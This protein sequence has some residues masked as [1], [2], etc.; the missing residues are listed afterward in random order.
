VD[1]AFSTV[2]VANAL[3]EI[4]AANGQQLDPMKLQKLVYIAHGWHLALADEPLIDSAVEAW[5]YGPVVPTLYQKTRRY[6]ASPIDQKLE[7]GWF[8]EL[9]DSEDLTKRDKAAWGLLERVWEE[10]GRYSGVHLSAMTHKKG[11]PWYK[12]WHDL[13][14][15]KTWGKN[16]DPEQIRDHY[17]DLARSSIEQS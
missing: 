7:R 14:G 11:T 10:Y 8:E 6:G 12:A 5:K 2:S 17:R 13:G 4:A 3:I 15:S 1:V 9:T 16:I